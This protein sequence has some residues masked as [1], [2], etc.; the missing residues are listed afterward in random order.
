ME[1]AGHL[2]LQQDLIEQKLTFSLLACFKHM[3]ICVY[4]GLSD[5]TAGNQHPD[6][7]A[8]GD[9]LLAL[10]TALEAASLAET[11]LREAIEAIPQGIV[12]LDEHDRYILWNEKY[13]QIYERSADL[14]QRGAKLSDTLRIGIA[15]GDYPE[16]IGRE[17][18]AGRP[19][20]PPARSRPTA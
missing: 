8:H 4:L 10:D 7:P 17:E 15:R 18:V 2:L 3:G 19:H 5:E 12:F 9:G 11:R 6:G 13:A 14:L 16:A 20:R 1:K